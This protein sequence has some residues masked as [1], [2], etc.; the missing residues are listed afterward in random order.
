MGLAA[1]DEGLK[2]RTPGTNGRPNI[3]VG[4][5]VRCIC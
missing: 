4:Y 2:G 3:K 1:R 5:G